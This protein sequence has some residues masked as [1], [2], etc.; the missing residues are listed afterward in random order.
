MKKFKLL[1]I[2]LFLIN[3]FSII[4]LPK[5][6]LKGEELKYLRILKTTTYI[7]QDKELKEKMFLLPYSY[8][9]KVEEEFENV[10]KVSYG[11]GLNGEPKIIGYA[12]KKS[13]FVCE[14]IPLNPFFI[15]KVSTKSSDVLFNDYTLNK[16]YFNIP[17]QSL[18]VYY[19]EI[20]TE[21]NISLCYCYYNSKLGYI[22]KNSLNNYSVPLNSDPIIEDE[23]NTPDILPSDN[24]DQTTESKFYL[25]ENLQIIIIVGISIISISV[26]YALFKPTKNK[27]CNNKTDCFDEGE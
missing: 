20:I 6:T 23:N 12:D 15:C 3:F 13:L 26:V 10:V 5:N 14:N 4:F 1:I 19:G 16:P 27:T 7:Y 25:S 17:T 11:E 18:L 22:D 2:A 24:P 21:N 8:Y 9:V